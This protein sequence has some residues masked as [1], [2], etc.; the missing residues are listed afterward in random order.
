MAPRQLIRRSLERHAPL[1][2]AQLCYV[3]RVGWHM[4]DGK[5]TALRYRMMKAGE[6]MFARKTVINS[7]GQAV[8]LWELNPAWKPPGRKRTQGS[9]R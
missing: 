4:S 1:S 7:R 9:Q 3:M 5:T 6:I 2:D 8:K